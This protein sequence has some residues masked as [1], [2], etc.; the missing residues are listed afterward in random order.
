MKETVNTIVIP[1]AGAGTRLRPI[2]YVTPKELLR[3]VDKPIVYYL[4]KEAYVAG[5]RHA[6]FITHFDRK[7]L[8]TFLK[9]EKSQEVLKEFPNL[10]FTFIETHHRLGDGQCLYEARGILKKEKAFAVTMGDLI[11][12]P[13]TSLIGEL[14]EIYL[15]NRTPVIS[16]EKIDR[17]K[18]KQ[19]GIIDPKKSN[20]RIHE[21]RSIIEKPDPKEAPSDY[22]MTGK[23]ILTPKIFSYL[24]K[25]LKE[26]KPNEEIKLANALR[27][28]AQDYELHAYTCKNRHFDTGNKADLIKTEIIF[29]LHHQELKQHIQSS[30]NDIIKHQK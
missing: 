13:G 16:V 2:T 12:F 15:K 19:Y 1:V 10:R 11:S 20:G 28:Y 3:L 7:D 8:K 27:D 22:A 26:R 4:L 5:I 25:L 21:I 18:S 9:S 30:L 23:Y 6:I 24:E 14:K 29:A 17:K